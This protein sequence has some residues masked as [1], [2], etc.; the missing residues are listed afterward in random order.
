MAPQHLIDDGLGSAFR[1]GRKPGDDKS[2]PC[3]PK[4]GRRALRKQNF[5]FDLFTGTATVS[6]S[7][8]SV[9][10]AG[11]MVATATT[12]TMLCAMVCVA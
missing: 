7:S 9:V 11:K 3:D 8:Q 1:S 12:G 2:F 4:L 6:G 10:L 5:T